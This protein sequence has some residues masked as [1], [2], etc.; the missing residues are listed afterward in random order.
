[1]LMVREP[2][3][4][5]IKGINNEGDE[6]FFT[7]LDGMF[8][9]NWSGREKDAQVFNSEETAECIVKELNRRHKGVYEYEIIQIAT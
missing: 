1:M 4:A 5:L 3:K 9:S 7:R 8:A 6:L 2:Q